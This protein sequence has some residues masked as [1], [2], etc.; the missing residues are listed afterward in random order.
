MNRPP[1]I[2]I[3]ISILVLPPCE[4]SQAGLL[5]RIGVMGDSLSAE[6]LGGLSTQSFFGQSFSPYVNWVEQLAED[7]AFNFGP[8]GYWGSWRREGYQFNHSSVFLATTARLLSP[9]QQHTGVASH[10]PTLAYLEIGTNY[11]VFEHAFDHAI[12]PFVGGGAFD[13]EDP[14]TMVPQMLIDFRTAMETVAGTAAGPTGTAMVVA[15]VPDAFRSPVL[16]L[17]EPLTAL[18]SWAPYRA[19]IMAFN[20]GIRQMAAERG[21]PVV[22]LYQ[23]VN[24]VLGPIDNPNDT[25][26][27]G[28]VA[29]NVGSPTGSPTDA[30]L[31]DGLH[32][33]TVVHGLMANEFIEAI[34]STYGAGVVPLTDAEILE[35]AMI[36]VPEPSTF[37]L[38]GL[39]LV[40]IAAFGWRK[41][42]RAIR[43]AND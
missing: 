15:T 3:T 30:F 10:N 32:P 7:R 16:T 6:Y 40:V 5:D 20:D 33:G 35:N 41:R 12:P 25:V 39:G 26:L 36:E 21:F 37:T 13:G 1:K 34:N 31:E 24:G 2:L 19:A 4:S 14:M 22:D 18:G 38:A 28:G 42:G 11:F 23:F 9:Q 8:Y 29:I 27:V 17:I 43:G